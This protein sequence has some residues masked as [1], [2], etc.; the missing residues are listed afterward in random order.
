MENG[1]GSRFF[2][3]EC[4]FWKEQIVFINH[5]VYNDDVLMEVENDNVRY[6]KRAM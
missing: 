3:M 4:K 5:M 6:D 2:I 1:S